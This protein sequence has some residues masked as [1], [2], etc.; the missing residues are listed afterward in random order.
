MQATKTT[1][2]THESAKRSPKAMVRRGLQ[3]LSSLV[4]VQVA[5]MLL[6]RFSVLLELATHFSFHALVAGVILTP[7]LFLLQANRMGLVSAGAT[8]ILAIVVSPWQLYSGSKE[9]NIE[10][11]STKSVTSIFTNKVKVLS[12][13]VLTSNRCYDEIQAIVDELDPDLIL[14]IEVR[15]GFLDELPKIVANYPILVSK[16]V[17]GGEGIAMLSRIEGTD[18]QYQAFSLDRQPAVEARIPGGRG[19]NL[20]L[21]GIHTL[22]PLPPRRAVI[23]DQQLD[24]LSQ[25]SNTLDAPICVCGDLNTTPWTKA[26]QDLLS[27]GFQDSRLGRGNCPSWPSELG[28]VGIP[29]D[30]VLTKGECKILE[31]RVIPTAPGSDHRPVYFEVEF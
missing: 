13:N 17:W 21:V 18:L 12:W 5:C 25:W 20:H 3:L 31:R 4:C 16:P 6:S 9:Q 19:K 28:P 23:R 29:I 2:T 8:A 14:F 26:F 10:S 22:S 27:D 24:S 7:A 11:D 1:A 30:H 15:P